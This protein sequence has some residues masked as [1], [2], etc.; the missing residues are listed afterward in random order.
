MKKTWMDE[1]NKRKRERER[2][3]DNEDDS[4]PG[5]L[6]IRSNTPTHSIS[7]DTPQS[8]FFFF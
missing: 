3:R 1:R 6:Q 5:D 8:F 7:L 4:T 2:K